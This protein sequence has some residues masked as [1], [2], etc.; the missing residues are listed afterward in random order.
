MKDYKEL[1]KEYNQ[2]HLLKFIELADEEKRKELINQIENIDF[3]KMA[4]LYKI[5]Q[6]NKDKAIESYIIEHTKFTDKYK[7]KEE[8]YKELEEIGEN[9]IKNNQYA[10]VTM[11][12]GQRNKIRTR[13]TKGKLFT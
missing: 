12:G 10:V 8:R 3:Q 11:A 1:L 7:I 5:S 2:E 9:V 4:E 6:R 13:W